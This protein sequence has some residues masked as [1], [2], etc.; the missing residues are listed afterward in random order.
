MKLNYRPEIDGLRAIAV[1]SVIFF[2]L[3]I[4]LFNHSLF[5]GGYLGVDIFFVI[6][7]Y[8]ISSII[9][10]ELNTT[11]SFSFKNFYER[12]IRRII[13]VLFVVIIAS[14]ALAWMYFLPSS[15]IDFA[16]SIISTLII[17]SNFYFLD[18]QSNYFDLEVNFRP[19]LHTWSLSIEE[20]F[21]LV[22]PFVLF[23]SFK[24]LKFFLFHLLIF[25]F[26]ISFFFSVWAS[27]VYPWYNFYLTPSRAWELL[28][29]SILA[30]VEINHRNK[31]KFNKFFAEKMTF[32]GFLLIIYGIFLFDEQIKHPSLKTLV[33]VIGTGLIIWFGREKSI[34]NKL[35]TY[36]SVVFLGLISYS[37]Y[38]WH[39]P[40]IIFNNYNW[41]IKIPNYFILL[42]IFVI[43]CISY[44]FIERIFRVKKIKFKLVCMVLISVFIAL[45]AFSFYIIKNNGF[46]NRFATNIENYKLDNQIH[47]KE[48]TE[49]KKKIGSP[50]FQ[51]NTKI[52]ILIVGDSHG[53]GLFNS[54]IQ[55]LDLF[56]LY[57]FAIDDVILET[58]NLL[59]YFKN[60]DCNKNK[61]SKFCKSDYVVI[62]TNWKVRNDDILE[63]IFYLVKKNNKKLIL[64]NTNVT[65]LNI[66]QNTIIDN[67]ILKKKRIPNILESEKIKKKY[68]VVNSSQVIR[69]RTNELISNFSKKNKIIL[70]KKEDLLCDRFKKK[71]DFF[72]ENGDKL[73]FD[74]SHFTIKGSKYLG[75]VIFEKNWFKLSN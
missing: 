15:F 73:Y 8:L 38:L 34:I 65:F 48:R 61:N 52:K 25:F 54:F 75:K 36:R 31:I 43:S 44:F 14:T 55:N 62:S 12:R 9:I 30:Y 11:G 5:S 2:H 23:F 47:G 13:P 22:F 16:K 33:P 29:G 1:I 20:Q 35:L 57:D 70:L 51:K 72:T 26:L 50:D 53:R 27:E 24:Y 40:I 10:K 39:Y 21:Y 56:P 41:S 74:S 45:N 46:K 71:C 60:N 67:F 28:F 37:L 69:N 42:I 66:G 18:V 6:S 4:N 17:I 49:F 32:F 64:T 68:Y 3:K 7:G 19:L 58:V 63:K 59:K